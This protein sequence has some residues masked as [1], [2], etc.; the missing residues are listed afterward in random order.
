MF[1]TIWKI[2]IWKK[3]IPKHDNKYVI[4]SKRCII[5]FSK[6]KPS[7]I[8]DTWTWRNWLFSRLWIMV[9][10][11][12]GY[13]RAF[14][15]H[16]SEMRDVEL[17]VARVVKCA[18]IF[19]FTPI[20]FVNLSMK[21]CLKSMCWYC[22]ANSPSEMSASGINLKKSKKDNADKEM[23]VKFLYFNFF[24]GDFYSVFG[25]RMC[26]KWAHFF[27]GQF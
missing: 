15:T 7:E 6:F 20:L 11:V 19:E 23:K 21:L 1:C 22:R 9:T 4:Y 8:F 13:W 2:W 5:C 3:K 14:L 27:F 26:R 17:R 10:L 16:S 18:F 12:F 25:D 24:F